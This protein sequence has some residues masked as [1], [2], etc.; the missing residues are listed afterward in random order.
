MGSLGEARS[1]RPGCS[2]FFGDLLAGTNLGNYQEQ[3]RRSYPI[4]S[5]ELGVDEHFYQAQ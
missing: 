5:K 3:H 4:W 1:N 2:V